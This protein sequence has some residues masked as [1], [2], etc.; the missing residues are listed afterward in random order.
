MWFSFLNLINI[1]CWIKHLKMNG[2]YCLPPL[3]WKYSSII[4]EFKKILLKKINSIKSYSETKL[5]NFSSW[6][7]GHSRSWRC[8]SFLALAPPWIRWWPQVF[9]YSLNSVPATY[10]VL[11]IKDDPVPSFAVVQ[12]FLTR[13]RESEDGEDAKVS[14][15]FWWLHIISPQMG[16]RKKKGWE[17]WIFLQRQKHGYS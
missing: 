14:Y 8:L 4:C 13:R 12:W 9:S 17:P 10:E 2:N 6:G 7:E 1:N 3:K 16:L 15:C 5:E 11:G